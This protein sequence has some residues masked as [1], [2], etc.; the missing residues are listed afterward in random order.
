MPR[1]TKVRDDEVLDL[2]AERGDGRYAVTH[3]DLDLVYG[4]RA[5]AL[6]PRHPR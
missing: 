4:S 2:D 1:S 5:T 6:R 3:Y